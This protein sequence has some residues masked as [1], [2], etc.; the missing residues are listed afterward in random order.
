MQLGKH[1]WPSFTFVSGLR[2]D[3]LS[4]TLSITSLV[5]VLLLLVSLPLFLKEW[6][7]KRSHL[8]VWFFGYLFIRG[9]I[10]LSPLN[11]L[12]GDSQ[13]LLAAGFA[14]LTARFLSRPQLFR[15]SLVV[16]AVSVTLVS[17]L[18]ICQFF[19]Q[20]SVGGWL[21][22]AG[23]RS[24]YPGTPGI[25]LASLH[26]TL[27]LRPY[28]AFPHPN[29]LAG[30][31]VVMLSVLLFA[32]SQLLVS[33]KKET[34][35]RILILGWF[36]VLTI[37]TVTLFLTLSR[38]AI[39][40][41]LV[42]LIGWIF[43]TAQNKRKIAV[44][45]IIGIIILICLLLYTGLLSRFTSLSFQDETVT[46][47]EQLLQASLQMIAAHPI[48]GV[49]LK[50][51]LPEL[52]RF[53]PQLSSFASLQPVHAVFVLW[54]AETGIIGG[55][56]AVWF[57]KILL[58]RMWQSKLQAERVG[59]YLLFGAV[60]VLGMVDHY[61]LTLPQGQLLFAFVIGYLWHTSSPLHDP[62]SRKKQFATRG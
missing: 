42:V 31:L 16:L 2:I 60:L 29:V 56:S 53:Q 8:F 50:N 61:F 4:P 51:F 58:L 6:I 41:W 47:R 18:A 1:Y 22:W 37:G 15:R 40:V 43:A 55:V 13:F 54:I 5:L 34:L 19:L 20:H 45:T 38:S 28:A 9:L 46:L 17:A 12:Y 23:E 3:Y 10:S 32:K 62:R 39:L 44:I 11:S 33:A 7:M 52:P 35:Q 25:A 30:F 36:A 59:K 26:G 49:G 24:F 48:F 21:Y 27:V 57:G 14:Y